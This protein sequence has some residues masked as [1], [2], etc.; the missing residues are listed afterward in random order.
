MH[1]EYEKLLAAENKKNGVTNVKNTHT[2]H[3]HI[4][5]EDL[6]I[7]EQNLIDLAELHFLSGLDKNFDYA[8]IDAD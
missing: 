1:M 5:K 3:K 6:E 4:D 7:S 8:R 2:S